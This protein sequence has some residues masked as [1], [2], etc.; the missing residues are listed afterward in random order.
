MI[1]TGI[2]IIAFGLYIFAETNY[3]IIGIILISMGLNCFTNYYKLQNIKLS[4]QMTTWK[5][6]IALVAFEELKKKYDMPLIRVNQPNGMV[7]WNKTSKQKIYDEIILKDENV[8]LIDYSNKHNINYICKYFVVKLYI[9]AD[10]LDSIL[11]LSVKLSYNK[12]KYLLTIF[13]FD[14]SDSNK[15]LLKILQIVNSN[16]LNNLEKQL[17][18]NLMKF[19]EEM[20]TLQYNLPQ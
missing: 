15:L 5:N 2:L 12:V 1:L 6:K 4:N 11:K 13:T 18:F 19:K 3:K 9:P 20:E 10:K 14:I 7:I 8:A 16:K 17:K